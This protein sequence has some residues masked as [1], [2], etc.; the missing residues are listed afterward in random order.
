MFSMS[1]S[2]SDDGVVGDVVDEGGDRLQSGHPGGSPSALAGDQLVAL[3]CARPDDDGLQ[4]AALP[5]R[6]RERQQ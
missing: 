4:H 3:G 5:D 6:V 2:S 1:A